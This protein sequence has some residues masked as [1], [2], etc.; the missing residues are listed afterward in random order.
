MERWSIVDRS[1]KAERRRI[2]RIWCWKRM[3]VRS[4]ITANSAERCRGRQSRQSGARSANRDCDTNSDETRRLRAMW[5]LHVSAVCREVVPKLL[6]D[7]NEY[8]RAWAI[9]LFA[10]SRSAAIG[11]AVSRVRRDGGQPFVASIVRLYLAS[12]MQRIPE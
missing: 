2:G 1:E 11:G 9:Q 5:A 7:Q 6:A 12:A 8:V 3:M 10:R 4:T